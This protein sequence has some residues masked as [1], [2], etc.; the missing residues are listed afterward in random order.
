[1]GFFI[2]NLPQMKKTYIW[3]K[4][5]VICNLCG[6]KLQRKIT[7]IDHSRTRNFLPGEHD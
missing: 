4:K 5:E 7:K 3:E 1:M 6:E 2:W